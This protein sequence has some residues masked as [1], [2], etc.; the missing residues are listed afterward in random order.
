VVS[1]LVGSVGGGVVGL[2][3]SPV[4]LVISP[5]RGGS[6][7][8]FSR[9]KIIHTNVNSRENKHTKERKDIHFIQT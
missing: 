2:P 9:K 5:A 3:H 1:L 4:F 7:T 8:G 6:V